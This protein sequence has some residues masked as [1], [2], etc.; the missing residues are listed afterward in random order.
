MGKIKGWTKEIRGTQI[1]YIKLNRR[2]GENS[3]GII[4]IQKIPRVNIHTAKVT[5]HTYSVK[6]NKSNWH[7]F[8]NEKSAVAYAMKMMRSNP[9]G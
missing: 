8:S 9:N 2:V 1:N 7:R 4:I 5:G 3:L 6:S